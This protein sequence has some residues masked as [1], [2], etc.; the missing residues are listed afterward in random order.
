[1]TV[2]LRSIVVTVTAVTTT[3]ITRK[4]RDMDTTRKTQGTD[5]FQDTMM[6]RKDTMMT[7]KDTVV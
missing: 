3:I 7:R 2:I 1:M 4:I 5:T 6:T